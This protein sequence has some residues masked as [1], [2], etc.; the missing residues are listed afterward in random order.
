MILLRLPFQM[1]PFRVATVAAVVGVSARGQ[2]GACAASDGLGSATDFAPNGGE[3]N[4][5]STSNV[6]PL[7]VDYFSGVDVVS[8]HFGSPISLTAFVMQRVFLF[9]STSE[10]FR[11]L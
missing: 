10:D 5:S 6:S 3:K 7:L 8:L 9:A 1:L 2:D 4:Q 11:L